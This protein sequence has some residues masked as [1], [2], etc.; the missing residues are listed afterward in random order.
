VAPEAELVDDGLV[1]QPDDI[2]AGADQVAGVGEGLLQGAGAAQALAPSSSST[3]RP[4]LA[5]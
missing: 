2:G 5:W 4:S 3:D 1:E